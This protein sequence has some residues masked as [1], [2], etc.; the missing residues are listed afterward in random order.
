MKI[1]QDK[2]EF[3]NGKRMYINAGIIGLC[4]VDDD[5]STLSLSYGCDGGILLPEDTWSSPDG[6][7]TPE[8]CVELAD[9]MLKRWTDFR[10]KYVKTH[11]SK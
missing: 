2:L 1:T 6:R 9:E 3:A 8:E 11:D 4:V 7:L 5:D 10:A